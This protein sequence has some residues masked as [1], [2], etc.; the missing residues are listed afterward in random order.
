M[1]II[2]SIFFP[3]THLCTKTEDIT[4]IFLKIF[5]TIQVLTISLKIDGNLEWNWSSALTPTW[6]FLIL[7]AMGWLT[8]AYLAVV[9]FARA[10]PHRNVSA[11]KATFW[12][13]IDATCILFG[14]LF[15]AI[16]FLY[17]NQ[18][19]KSLMTLDKEET[20]IQPFRKH[21]MVCTIPCFDGMW[22]Y[23]FISFWDN[24]HMERQREVNDQ[25]S[26]P[27]IKIPTPRTYFATMDLDSDE[28]EDTPQKWSQST[29][30]LMI[31][32][33]L[34]AICHS[35]CRLSTKLSS[36]RRPS[37]VDSENWV[38]VVHSK[39]ILLNALWHRSL[40]LLEADFDIIFPDDNGV[41][42]PENDCCSKG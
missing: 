40:L 4:L 34:N 38:P 19:G 10:P 22:S 42:R 12:M 28:Q 26:D 16:A 41:E 29:N 14:S 23:V 21:F 1:K 11:I 17:E 18:A 20:F 13:L 15:L 8:I 27:S 6:I 33:S 25:G 32:D 31:S 35:S 39:P 37:A 3:S 2:Q 9:E 36:K 30:F 5:I 24:I 7:F